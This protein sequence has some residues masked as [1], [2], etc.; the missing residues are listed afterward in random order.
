MGGPASGQRDQLEGRGGDIG[1]SSGGVDQR[2]SIP[3]SRLG[4]VDPTATRRST[5]SR[6]QS[7]VKRVRC[8]DT[9]NIAH[10]SLGI[11]YSWVADKLFL[12]LGP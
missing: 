1:Q 5:S 4:N 7:H 9:R 11:A 2:V 10:R 6:I 12:P 8:A 3:R